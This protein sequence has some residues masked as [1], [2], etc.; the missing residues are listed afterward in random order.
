M[1]EKHD[2]EPI[3]VL[4]YNHIENGIYVGTNVCCVTHFVKELKDKNIEA[5]ISLEAKKLDKPFGVN[6]YVWLPVEKNQ[7]PSQDQL[8][9][10]TEAIDKLIKLKKKIYIH[11]ENGHS[12][13]TTLLA[14][15]FIKLGKN[16]DEAINLIK[17][18][19]PG[20]HLHDSQILALKIFEKKI[21]KS[22]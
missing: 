22:I 12:R 1:Y 14:A 13:T 9:F 6:F 18:K 3:K 20:V 2:H 11:C 10:G 5:D 15:Y 4:E 8:D 19:R 16:M 17:N 21:S 7:A